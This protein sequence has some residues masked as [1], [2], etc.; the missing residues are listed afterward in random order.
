MPDMFNEELL[1]TT[2]D[3]WPSAR[4]WDV[5]YQIQVN[6][7]YITRNP[8]RSLIWDLHVV[9][10]GVSMRFSFLGISV[11]FD[12]DVYINLRSSVMFVRG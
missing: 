6:C 4:S 1:H 7:F 10:I 5:Q 11:G 2:P 12:F 9:Y 3:P 8:N